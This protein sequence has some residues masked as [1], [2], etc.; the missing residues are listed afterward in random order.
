[1]RFISTRAGRQPITL[2][3]AVVQGL[4]ADGGLFVPEQIPHYTLED[5]RAM[6]GL[7]YADV[8]CRLL[9]PWMDEFCPDE[10]RAMVDAAYRPGRFEDDVAPLERVD[11]GTYLLELFHGPTLAFKDV[12]LQFLPHLMVA[13]LK[14]Q[15]AGGALV[16]AATSG[17][18]GKAAMEGFCDVAGTRVFVLYPD[19]GV[20][21]SQRRQMVT[22]RGDNVAVTAIQGNFDDAQSAIKRLLADEG[23]KARMQ[24]AGWRTTSANSINIGRLMPQ[25]VY[26]FYA[27][28]NLA[29]RGDIAIGDQVDFVVP[30]GNFG[31]ILA[32][33]YAR[34]MGLPVGRLVC[35]SNANRVLTD[36]FQ[37][38]RYN[39]ARPFYKTLSPSMDILVSSNLERYLFE[40]TGRDAGRVRDWMEGLARDRRYDIGD[41]LAGMQRIW[42]GSADDEQTAQTIRQ[43]WQQNARLI[44]PHTAVAMHVLGQYRQEGGVQRPAVVLSTASPFKFSAALYDIL[45]GKQLEEG[46][47]ARELALRCRLPL[48]GPIA[49]L[50]RLPVRHGGVCRVEQ[51]A[52]VLEAW[53]G[54]G[55]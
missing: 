5:I 18:T 7:P 24:Q 32:G 27:Y 29:A 20:S 19:A 6:V 39:A 30:T 1:M 52:P 50:E 8:A 9:E 33:E 37:K 15:G 25:V 45:F 3:Q 14:K 2:S 23:F 41:A 51:V 11:A 22:Q 46:A 49:E 16:I 17:D 35:A 12:A 47:A 36:F 42:A 26:Y 40:S 48:P 53:M 38:G 10:V 21:P 28:A 43:V 54:V 31:N 55:A 34:R 4:A 13:C 44:D